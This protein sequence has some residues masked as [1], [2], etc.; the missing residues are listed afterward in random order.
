MTQ[1]MNGWS[2]IKGLAGL[3]SLRGSL[4]DFGRAGQGLFQKTRG[5]ATKTTPFNQTPIMSNLRSGARELYNWGTASS[6]QGW[7]RG[8]TAAARLGLPT[9]AAGGAAWG[10]SRD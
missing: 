5:M 3:G 1:A 6:S 7:R 9:A 8:A 2:A 4:R 10:V